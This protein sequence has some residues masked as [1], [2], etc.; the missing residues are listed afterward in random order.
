M[1]KTY[2]IVRIR[3]KEKL[4]RR[5]KLRYYLNDKKHLNQ[6]LSLKK[7]RILLHR[8]FKIKINYNHEN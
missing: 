4:E 1:K 7:L 3:A 8:V 5:E 2:V 6:N